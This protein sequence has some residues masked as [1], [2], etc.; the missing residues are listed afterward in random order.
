MTTDPAAKRRRIRFRADPLEIAQVDFGPLDGPFTPSM[1]ALIVEE[2]PM[3]GC[4]LVLLQ[5][6][7]CYIGAIC[8]VK[9]GRLS[10]LRAEV[11]WQQ[12]LGEDAMRVGFMFLE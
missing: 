10:P 11:R 5:T 9:V 12:L 6:P 7:D 1:S 8:R 4:G 3:A 2:S